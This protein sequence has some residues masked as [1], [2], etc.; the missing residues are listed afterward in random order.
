MDD[1]M[2][3]RPRRGVRTLLLTLLLGG[4]LV[5]ASPVAAADDPVLVGAGDIGNC[6]SSGDEATGT[7]LDGIPGTV[8]ALGDLAYPNGSTVNFRDCYAPSWGRHRDR[9]RP[10]AG[11]HEYNTAGAAGYFDYFG[12]AAG[13]RGK[14]W[15]SYDV[16]A[17]HV[18][19][20]NSHCAAVGGCGPTSAQVAWLKSDLAANA[21]EHVLAYWHHPRYSSGLHGNSVDVQTFWDV[22]YAAGAELVLS[23]HDHDYERFAPQD[24][25]GRADPTFGIR[26][27][28]VGTGGT[29][30]RAK[31]ASVPN[32]QVFSTT[33][34]VLKLTLHVD[35]YDWEFVP[36]AGKTFADSGSGTAH[37]SPPP[38][39]RRTFLATGDS[40][41]D[42]AH[43]SRNYGHA[44]TLVTDGNTSNGLDAHA[45]LKVKI[46]DTTGTIDRAALRLWVTNATSNGP[47]IA[48]TSCSWTPGTITW[49]NR[50]AASGPA[51]FDMPAAKTGRWTELDVTRL[52][53][54]NKLY[55]FL[56]RP[57]SS[58]G[59]IV[60]SNQGANPPRLVVET[61]PAP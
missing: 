3:A 42:Q 48:P 26:Q 52:V 30:L 61:V 38:R 51:V 39:T 28:V 20:L 35:G 41:V 31:S 58:D 8:I 19:V 5:P 14:G 4:A 32:S 15:Y 11:N 27:F 13:L 25:W 45:Y 18:V 36:I 22:L 29:T 46:S 57:T 1:H 24:P 53:R 16:G 7:L 50:P 59:L 47:T 60:S 2:A 23:G 49:S 6:S 21:G 44:T 54:S 9:T 33:H 34:G 43:G 37:G 40:W 56:L 17:W 10:A 12:T 55:C